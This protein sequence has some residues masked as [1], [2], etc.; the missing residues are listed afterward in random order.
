[1]AKLIPT[2]LQQVL[3]AAVPSCGTCRIRPVKR[4]KD[5]LIPVIM[6]WDDRKTYSSATDWVSEAN[7]EFGLPLAEVDVDNA[8]SR[9]VTAG[10]LIYNSQQQA[11]ELPTVLRDATIKRIEEAEKP[12]IAAQ[13]SWLAEVGSLV[14]DVPSDNLWNC[15]ITYAGKRSCIMA[16]KLSRFSQTKQRPLRILRIAN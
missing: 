5:G 2:T 10:S 6:V 4:E 14:P 15:L 13:A 3:Q 9:A 1:M 16:T 8:F 7:E 11:Y 12:E